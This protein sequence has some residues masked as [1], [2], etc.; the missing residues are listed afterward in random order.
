MYFKTNPIKYYQC[1]WPCPLCLVVFTRHVEMSCDCVSPH[2]KSMV[3]MCHAWSTTTAISIPFNM[4]YHEFPTEQ[5]SEEGVNGHAALAI[6]QYYHTGKAE[7]GQLVKIFMVTQGNQQSH[8]II[9]VPSIFVLH[10]WPLLFCWF[11]LALMLHHN[12]RLDIWPHMMWITFAKNFLH[13]D[14]LWKECLAAS[15]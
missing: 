8:T 12:P 11:M 14:S 4:N 3:R 1:I 9:R 7:K 13:V 2:H 15:N 6:I 10:L 5:P